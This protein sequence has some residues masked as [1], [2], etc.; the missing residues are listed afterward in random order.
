[1]SQHGSFSPGGAERAQGPGISADR[2]NGKFGSCQNQ[3][4]GSCRRDR[5]TPHHDGLLILLGLEDQPHRPPAGAGKRLPSCRSSH[6][7][8]CRGKVGSLGKW[9]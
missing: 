1:V 2:C 6:T 7:A 4:T 9:C 5:A 8:C 3:P